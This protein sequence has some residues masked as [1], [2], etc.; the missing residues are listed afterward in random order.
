MSLEIESG[1][2]LPTMRRFAKNLDAKLEAGLVPESPT[3]LYFE[4]WSRYDDPLYIF[5]AYGDFEVVEDGAGGVRV[6][7]IIE[8]VHYFDLPILSGA[9]LDLSVFTGPDVGDPQDALI[10]YLEE[11]DATFNGTDDDDTLI[12]YDPETVY[13]G[14]GSDEISSG[15]DTLLVYGGEG[16]DRISGGLRSAVVHGEDGDDAFRWAP[17]ADGATFYGGEGEDTLVYSGRRSDLSIALRADGGIEV[18]RLDDP[19]AGP[20]VLY[21]VEIFRIN[22]IDLL[23]VGPPLAQGESFS[24]GQQQPLSIPFSRLLANDSSALDAILDVV[25]AIDPVNGTVEIVGDRIVF[26]PAEGFRGTAG[27]D[28]VI[29]NGYAE[30]T[31]HVAI[32]VTQVGDPPEAQDDAFTLLFNGTVS[33]NVFADNGFGEDVDPDGDAIEVSRAAGQAPTHPD[34]ITLPSGALL[35][36]AADGAF[37]YDANGAFDDLGIGETAMDGFSYS[38]TDD[39]GNVDTAFV[40][41]TLTKDPDD[42]PDAPPLTDAEAVLT[43]RGVATEI[44]IAFLLAGDLSPGGSPLVFEGVR[45]AVHGSVE[46]VGSVVRFTPDAGYVGLA[47]FD[48]VVGNAGGE[49][50]QQV[51]VSI[52]DGNRAPVARDDVASVSEAGTLVI[53]FRDGNGGPADSDPNGDAL[54]VVAAAGTPV[55][56][57]SPILLP[58]GAVL[59]PQADGSFLYDPSGAFDTLEGGETAVDSFSYTLSDALG[60]TDTATVSIEIQGRSDP[61]RGTAGD[62][63]LVGG[64]NDDR[65]KGHAGDDVL[66][67]RAGDDE[68]AGGRGEDALLGGRGADRLA[69]GPGADLLRGG[70]GADLLIGGAAADVL[71]GGGG[72]DALRAGRGRDQLIGGAGDDEL[73]G[74][75]GRDFFV[76]SPG[77]G[78]DEVVDFGTGRDALDLR[79]FNGGL[80]D[81][82]LVEIDGDLLVGVD[83]EV[84]ARLLG[85]RLE[86]FDVSDVYF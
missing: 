50:A 64:R 54:S 3:K 52:L 30:S 42:L 16:D 60:A 49:T 36:I 24:T 29:S 35:T 13:G 28:Y 53:D 80:A 44:D 58:S 21:D 23:F 66:R 56:G 85:V 33:G 5:T 86:D 84:V 67:G 69:G 73:T 25:E 20:T 31:A 59:V 46:V 17:R 78:T 37:L 55:S 18:I 19:A 61:I 71:F 45:N 70:G 57:L 75:K 76:F 27:F 10:A 22:D 15:A 6:T 39:W 48:Y 81:L 38:V 40:R 74:G 34:A 79:D 2:W 63:E 26:T 47:T 72:A 77:G 51:S 4:V 9:Q 43:Q 7:G 83:G 68:L 1:V 62:D 41:L 12:W 82:T 32:D 8:E 65:I 11:Q 14:A